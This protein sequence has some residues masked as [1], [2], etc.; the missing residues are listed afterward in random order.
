M[1]FVLVDLIFRA[2]LIIILL[3]NGV[4][5]ADDIPAGRTASVKKPNFVVFLVDDLGIGDIGC[6][7]NDTIRTPNIDRLAE[8]G[9]KLN[10]NLSPES[11]CT[12]SRAAMLTGRYAI[13]SGLASGP[14]ELRVIANLACTAGLP[15]N[16]TTFADVLQENGYRTSLVGKWHLGLHCESRDNCH[17]PL[18]MGFHEFYGLPF[19]NMRDCGPISDG[20][21]LLH[22]LQRIVLR[23]TITFVILGLGMLFTGVMRKKYT[24]LFLFFTVLSSLLTPFVLQSIASRLSCL[25]MRGFEVVEQPT[26]LENLTVRFTNE[27]KGFIHKNKEKPFLLFMSYAK[28]HAVLFTSPKF[29]GHSAHGRYGDNVEEMDW[30]VGEIISTLEKEN[31]LEDT[32]VYFTSDHGPFLEIVSHKTGE[33]LGGSNGGYKGGQ[34]PTQS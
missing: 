5:S 28:V 14:G 30:S 6:F 1:F 16:E 31:L 22:L 3:I 11:I 15:N 20:S 23:A 33:L 8:R 19:T 32:F 29:K 10:Q 7:G 17:H 27:A 25:T 34:L 4:T 13:R 2:E 26:I 24:V 18:N 9:A 12:P 21:S